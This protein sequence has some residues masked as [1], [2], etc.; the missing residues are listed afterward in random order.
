[1]TAD[2]SLKITP[3]AT[4]QVPLRPLTSS[5]LTNW[6]RCIDMKRPGAIKNPATVGGHNLNCLGSATVQDA[7]LG[8]RHQMD[9]ET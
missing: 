1:M 9:E 8:E 6:N 5:R 4:A 3:S 2:P 7:V